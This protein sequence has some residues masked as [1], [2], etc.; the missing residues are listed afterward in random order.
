LRSLLALALAPALLPAGPIPTPEAHFGFPMG[1]DRHLVAWA[2]VVSYFHELAAASPR[3]RLLELGPTTEGRPMIAAIIASPETRTHL[4]RYQEIQRRLADPRLTPPAAAAALAASG[5]AVVM[6]TCSIHSTEVAST[7]SAVQFAYRMAAE[8][9]P[10]IRA[11]LNNVI[12]ILVPSLNPDGVDIVKHWY[13]STL[14]TAY[15]GTYPPQLYQKYAGHDNNRDWYFFTQRETR[16]VVS[17]L[18]NVWHPQIVYDVHQ[19][20]PFA[21]R[22]FF[23]PWLDPLD[24]NVDSRLFDES[25]A[26]TSAMA[27]DLA[28]SGRTGIVTHALY[29]FWSPARQ[30]AS[31]HAGIRILSESASARLATPIDVAPEQIL[32]R[33]PGFEPRRR[34]WNYLDPWTGGR[35]TLGDIVHDQLIAIESCLSE[36]AQRRQRLLENFYQVGRDAIA[37]T[38]PF[39]FLIPMPQRDMGAARKLIETLRFAGVEVERTLHDATV[40]G[41]Q[42]PEGSYAIRMRQPYSGFAK[43]L[44]EVQNYPDL[45]RYPGSPPQ[46]PYDVAAQTLPLLMGVGLVRAG[47]AFPLAS[48]DD[49]SLP[50]APATPPLPAEDSRAWIQ[51]NRAWAAGRQVWRNSS[52]GAFVFDTPPDRRE[53]TRLARPR[54][55]VYRSWVPAIDEGWTRWVLDQFGFPYQSL[56]NPEIEAGGLEKHFDV[57]VFPDETPRD[58]ERGYAPGA[59]PALYTGGLGAK[60]AE[61]LAGF[62]GSGGTLVFLNR[63]SRFAVKTLRLPVRDAA[64]DLPDEEYYCPGSLLNVRLQAGTALGYGLPQTFTVWNE[65]SPVWDTG[66]APGTQAV[67]KYSGSAVLA[68]GW[69]LGGERIA[70]LSPLVIVARGSGHIV[71][72]GMRPQ[73]RGQSYLTFKLFFNSLL[74]GPHG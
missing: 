46:K 39:A 64:E 48:R 69:L 19:Q 71:L 43:T 45:R 57:I 7:E 35:W 44:L 31:Y 70:R 24:P 61:A 5:K 30:Y 1:A 74:L 28:E 23:P 66:E 59:M 51:V 16:L 8:D 73:Y 12:L 34:S 33:L 14:G 21:S 55:G 18:H 10:P 6:V 41:R 72:F 11:I 9:T 56:T 25:D 53:W 29:D 67:L 20:G 58:I 38:S 15:E 37:R 65:Q 17:Q 4:D 50:R 40:N 49:G 68:S 54:I 22:M 27:A 42:I 60:A 52:T 32:T 47:A 36:A 26:I 3:V 13:D 62:A 63:S 2:S